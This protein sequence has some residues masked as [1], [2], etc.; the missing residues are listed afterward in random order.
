MHS[1]WF[2]VY[3]GSFISL[4]LLLLFVIIA[5]SILL[6]SRMLLRLPRNILLTCHLRLLM[7]FQ[8]LL[9]YNDL[10]ILAT[11]WN[12]FQ[13][14]FVW[15]FSHDQSWDVG[16]Q[17]TTKIFHYIIEAYVLSTW[18]LSVIHVSFNQVA[19]VV[20]CKLTSSEVVFLLM[21]SNLILGIKSCCVQSV[22]TGVRSY[23]LPLWWWRIHSIHLEFCAGTLVSVFQFIKWLLTWIYCLYLVYASLV[24]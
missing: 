13:L 23:S 3:F 4:L 15:C 7:E 8:T 10:D 16:R 20:F 2:S 6:L 19:K 11:S 1:L 18:D 12:V 14:G 22:L 21:F 24:F 5:P 17:K 9:V